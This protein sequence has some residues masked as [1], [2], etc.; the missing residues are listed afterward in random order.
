MEKQSNIFLLLGYF[1]VILP[2]IIF[3]IGF[4]NVPTAVIGIGLIAIS[5]YFIRKDCPKIWI[6]QNKK[7]WWLMAAALLIITIWVCY[8]GI[9][10]L[11]FQTPDHDAR[12]PIFEYLVTEKWPVIQQGKY[13]LTYYIGFWLPAA[14]IGKIF[15]SITVGYFA[16][17][18]WAVFGIFLAF[19]YVT[20]IFKKKI[21]LPLIIFMF[22]SGLDILGSV[23]FDWLNGI[24]PYK[25][26]FNLFLHL[27]WY[28]PN[29]QFSSFT[30]QLYWVFNQAI[31]AWVIT[32]LLYHQK[33][34]K[35][36]I[37]I[38]SCM[39]LCSTLPAIGMLPIVIY[40]GI[41]N[42]EKDIKNVFNK[43]HFINM[44]K[45][46]F[47]IQNLVGAL[48][49]TPITYFY[50][51]NNISGGNVGGGVSNSSQWPLQMYLI[52]F[53]L[54]FMLEVG[55]YLACVWNKYKKDPMFYLISLCF[56]IYPFIHVGSSN[57]FCMRA[58]IPALIILYLYIVSMFYGEDN[59]KN[60]II[61][62]IITVLIIIGSMTPIHEISRSIYYTSQGFTK[63]KSNSNLV[64][65]GNFY[66]YAEGNKFL[67][68]FGK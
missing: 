22:F 56:L 46:G 8:S 65:S 19:Y 17:I 33:N 34:N 3:L 62:P 38:Y 25:H 49:I 50:L 40:L 64:G 67:K 20:A 14:V 32:M 16:Q 10:A 44:L 18:A 21:L 31:P 2:I 45:C 13:I 47:S 60:K 43:N 59:T 23:I 53:L 29:F 55:L 63:I 15:N 61:A 35:N 57:D 66:G 4:C 41:K 37:F 39:F 24:S 30:T 9:G 28:F 48:F 51:T 6:P 1:Y 7:E 5:S 12:N 52:W 26:S 58:T 11:S 42:G 27:E 54:F 36:L 68:Y